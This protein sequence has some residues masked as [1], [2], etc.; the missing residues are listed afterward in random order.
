[1]GISKTELFQLLE[2]KDLQGTP[3][4][5]LANKVD[6]TPHLEQTDIISGMNLDYIHENPWNI[7]PISAK[8]GTNLEGVVDWILKTSKSLDSKT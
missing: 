3:M 2:N 5:I 4:L 7:I 6:I 8:D 1:L